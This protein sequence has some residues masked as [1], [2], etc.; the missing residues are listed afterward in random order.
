V[1]WMVLIYM[2]FSSW[3]SWRAVGICK[4]RNKGRL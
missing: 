3:N 4:F 2:G 1:I